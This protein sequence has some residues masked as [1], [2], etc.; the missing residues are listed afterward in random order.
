MKL[1]VRLRTLAQLDLTQA[2]EWYEKSQAGL[3]EEFSQT[4]VRALEL[5]AK[6]P[7]RYPVVERDVREA[8]IK[9]Y[10][11]CINYRVRG[12]IMIVLAIY[13]QSRDPNGWRGR[14]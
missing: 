11:F 10:P 9:G 7:E 13:H 1:I 14:N 2:S 6:H 3:G 12:N 5:L 8:P 4:V